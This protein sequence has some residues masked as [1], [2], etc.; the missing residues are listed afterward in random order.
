MGYSTQGFRKYK[1]EVTNVHHKKDI[2]YTKKICLRCEIIFESTGR[3]TRLCHECNRSINRNT[4]L[5]GYMDDFEVM[6]LRS[7]K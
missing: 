7:L 5:N 2:V 6:G 3:F 4:D 1:E